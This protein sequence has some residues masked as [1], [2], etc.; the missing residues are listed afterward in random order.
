M[1]TRRYRFGDA[2]ERLTEAEIMGFFQVWEWVLA[3]ML[4]MDI[5]PRQ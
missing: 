1:G 4:I 2:G 5:V 3:R